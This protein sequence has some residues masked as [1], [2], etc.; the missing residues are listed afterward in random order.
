MYIR[1]KGE[2]Q[3]KNISLAKCTEVEGRLLC[4]GNIYVP[5]YDALKLQSLKLYYDAPSA[6]HPGCEKMFE[7][8]SRDYYWPLILANG[9]NLTPMGNSV[10]FD[11]YR[12]L[13]NHDKKYQW[14]W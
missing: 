8:I 5:D 12:Y 10:Y 11:P 3:S 1:N 13:N 4:R 6:G 2:R 9:A 14:T 7:L